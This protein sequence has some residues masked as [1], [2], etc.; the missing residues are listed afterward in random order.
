[1]LHTATHLLQQALKQVL[2]DHVSQKG[3][4]ITA[5]RLRFDFNHPEKVEKDKLAEV[6][7][8]VNEQIEKAL[9]IDFEEMTVEEAKA[10]GAIGVFS[11]RYDEKVKVYSIGDFSKEI[12]GGPHAANTSDLGSFKINKEESSSRGIRRIKASIGKG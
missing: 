1:R 6:E 7:G 4:N 2:G 8:I 3:S 5:D 12:C 11:D 9:S 10:A